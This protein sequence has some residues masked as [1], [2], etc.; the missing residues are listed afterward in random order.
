MIQQK[1]QPMFQTFRFRL[2][3]S[4]AQAARMNA[5]LALARCFFNQ[6][7]SERIAA[8]QDGRPLALHDQLRQVAGVRRADACYSALHSHTMQLIV[9]EVDRAWRACQ[10]RGGKGRPPSLRKEGPIRSLG[11]KQFRNGFHIDGRRLRLFQIGRVAVRWHRQLQG[12]IKTL[13]V[14]REAGKWFAAFAC[15]VEPAPLPT[16][17]QEIGIDLGTDSLITLSSGER[18]ANP[19]WALVAQQRLAALRDRLHRTLPGSQAHRKAQLRVGRAYVRL[20]AR[21]RDYLAK[22][23]ATLIASNDRIAV[24][25]LDVQKLAALRASISDAGWGLFRRLLVA[26]AKR[27]G[28]LITFV[29]P[30]WTSQTC[31]AC[32]HLNR[33]YRPLSVREFACE[34]CEYRADRDVNAARV[35]L[36]RAREMWE[37]TV[38]M[39]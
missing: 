9:A 27:T 35:V 24:E 11:F 23:V 32:G 28:R 17:G 20:A 29:N 38:C 13:R 15:V 33:R 7:L 2:Y 5:A 25:N 1:R 16:T 4:K 22:I 21:R 39:G 36:R 34:R 14:F 8:H 3:P 30:A 26:K 37:P 19:R 18:I 10:Q 6:L 12:I 31:S